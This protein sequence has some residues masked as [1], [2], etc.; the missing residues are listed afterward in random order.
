MTILIMLK[1]GDITNKDITYNW[2]YLSMTLLLAVNK[3]L[4]R[5][6]KFI[7]VIN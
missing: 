1:I 4:T 3:K 7:D 6:V 5:N 2:F